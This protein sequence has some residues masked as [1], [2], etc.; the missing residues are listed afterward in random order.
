M[1]LALLGLIFIGAAV[2]VGIDVWRENTNTHLAV[3][4]FGH[5][6]SQPPWV[7][8][9]VGAVCGA[10]ILLGLAMFLAGAAARRLCRTQR[11]QRGIIQRNPPLGSTAGAA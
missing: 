7:V 10:L 5:T 8:I 2:A 1:I 4:G 6:F 11:G 3:Q 9:V